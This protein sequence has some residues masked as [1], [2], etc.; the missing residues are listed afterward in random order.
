MTCAQ[1]HV[2]SNNRAVVCGEVSTVFNALLAAGLTMVKLLN[3]L[4]RPRLRIQTFRF[5]FFRTMEREGAD[6]LTSVC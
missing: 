4:N 3:W 5:F 6:V 2:C 1:Q